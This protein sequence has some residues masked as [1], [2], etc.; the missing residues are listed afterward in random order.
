MEREY[1]NQKDDCIRTVGLP[2]FYSVYGISVLKAEYEGHLDKEGKI[3]EGEW[4]QSGYVFPLNM[5]RVDEAQGEERIGMR[6][7]GQPGHVAPAGMINPR[8]DASRGPGT[9]V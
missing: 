8:T 7:G 3:I 6:I 4:R 5:E 1:K 9:R 2:G